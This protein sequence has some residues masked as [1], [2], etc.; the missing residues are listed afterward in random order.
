MTLLHVQLLLVLFPYFILLL[1]AFFLCILSCILL[2]FSQLRSVQFLLTLGFCF[3]LFLTCKA[4]FHLYDC[5][6]CFPFVMQ[7]SVPSAHQRGI[8]CQ[9]M[10]FLS[11]LA[12]AFWFSVPDSIHVCVLHMWLLLMGCVTSQSLTGVVGL[13]YDDCLCEGLLVGAV[14]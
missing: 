4:F 3:A 13:A 7:R 12:H 2:V 10:T 14:A 5:I 1:F 8:G 9:R 11:C 6:L